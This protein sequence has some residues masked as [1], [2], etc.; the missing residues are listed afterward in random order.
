[1][2][3]N[4]DLIIGENIVTKTAI[5]SIKKDYLNSDLISC[6]SESGNTDG[7]KNTINKLHKNVKLISNEKY[8]TASLV[9]ISKEELIKLIDK[10]YFIKRKYWRKKDS[11][12]INLKFSNIRRKKVPFNIRD[13]KYNEFTSELCEIISNIDFSIYTITYDLENYINRMELLENENYFLYFDLVAKL[14]CFNSLKAKAENKKIS[15]IINFQSDNEKKNR[16]TRKHV[17]Q[18]KRY[19]ACVVQSVK[20]IYYMKKRIIIEST[21]PYKCINLIELSDL[22]TGAIYFHNTNKDDLKPNP[23]YDVIKSKIVP[24]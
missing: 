6:F 23:I 12:T 10:F 13:D 3:N 4:I 24:T 2:N 20:K 22:V 17:K 8:I 14:I 15:L 7:I 19:M 1:M 21:R 16:Y 18:L 9:S 5:K 11:H